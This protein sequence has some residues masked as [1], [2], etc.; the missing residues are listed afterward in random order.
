MAME[1][2]GAEIAIEGGYVLAKAKR[3]LKGAHIRFEKVSVGRHP[4][5]ADGGGHG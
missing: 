2:L 5:R 4:R 1:K 3:G